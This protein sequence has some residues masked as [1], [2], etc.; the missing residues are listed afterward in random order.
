MTEAEIELEIKNLRDRISELK[1]V[2]EWREEHW[3]RLRW[4]ST[5]FGLL[6]LIVAAGFWSSPWWL[7]PANITSITRAVFNT[8]G[9][10]LFLASAQATFLAQA[11]IGRSRSDTR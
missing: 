6:C 3:R 9:L 1:E 2:Q 7:D 5:V 10:M 4:G 8:V 11:L